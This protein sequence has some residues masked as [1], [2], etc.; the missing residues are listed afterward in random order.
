[1]AEKIVVN[2]EIL[3]TVTSNVQQQADQVQQIINVLSP[4]IEDLRAGGWI[5][6]GANAFYQEMDNLVMPTLVALKKALEETQTTFKQMATDFDNAD[7][8][9]CQ[10]LGGA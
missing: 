2:F 10:L 6:K 4:K 5:G 8:E 1:M 3:T 7:D 9:I